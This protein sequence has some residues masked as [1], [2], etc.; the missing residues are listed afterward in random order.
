MANISSSDHFQCRDLRM[1][2][3]QTAERNKYQVRPLELSGLRDN[4]A[5][6]DACAELVSMMAHW[7]R[8]PENAGN[9]NLLSVRLIR[10]ACM[11]S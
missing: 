2:V 9:S 11:L 1:E 3:R 4:R 10:T 6:R 8:C 7:P 5:T